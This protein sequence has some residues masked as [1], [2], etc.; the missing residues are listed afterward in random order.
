[1]V[2]LTNLRESDGIFD[3]MKS[4]CVYLHRVSVTLIDF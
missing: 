3:G 2:D 1:M 4:K